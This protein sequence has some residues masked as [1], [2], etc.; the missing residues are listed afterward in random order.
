MRAAHTS[1]LSHAMEVRPKSHP[2]RTGRHMTGTLSDGTVV[3]AAIV[4]AAL[5]RDIGSYTDRESSIERL[6]T[7]RTQR[8]ADAREN[9]KYRLHN[10]IELRPILKWNPPKNM[11]YITFADRLKSFATWPRLTELPTPESLAEAGFYYE[12]LYT[13]FYITFNTIFRHLSHTTIFTLLIPQG[14]QMRLRAFT[15]ILGYEIGYRPIFP[16][17]NMLTGL[18]PLST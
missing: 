13:L 12:G 18:L 14:A 17:R 6:I 9:L 11:A 3:D 4:N 8:L 1:L 16:L 15:A 2:E 10:F 5:G 7:R